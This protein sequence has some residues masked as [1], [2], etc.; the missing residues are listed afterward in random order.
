MTTEEERIKD[1]E[2]Y[3]RHFKV[4][5]LD[6]FFVKAEQSECHSNLRKDDFEIYFRQKCYQ[7][8]LASHINSFKSIIKFLPL[9]SGIEIWK[10][11]KIYLHKTF[12]KFFDDSSKRVKKIYKEEKMKCENSDLKI[13]KDYFKSKY[14]FHYN[15]KDKFAEQI[16]GNENKQRYFQ[17]YNYDIFYPP[18]IITMNTEI[19]INLKDLCEY[20]NINYDVTIDK[21]RAFSYSIDIFFPN[22][23]ASQSSNFT[24]NSYELTLNEMFSSV[25]PVDKTDQDEI[26]LDTKA[27]DVMRNK[28]NPALGFVVNNLEEGGKFFENLKYRKFNSCVYIKPARWIKYLCIH[29]KVDNRSIQ[30]KKTLD[31]LGHVDSLLKFELELIEIVD[32]NTLNRLID[33]Y[34]QTIKS[35]V[36]NTIR[37]VATSKE[38]KLYSGLREMVRNIVNSQ[39]T[40]GSNTNNNQ[41]N[42]NS[43]NNMLNLNPLSPTTIINDEYAE[44]VDGDLLKY[45]LTLRFLKL[46]DYKFYILNLLNYFRYV[47]KKFAID[48]YK[49]EN[50]N[51]KKSEDYLHLTEHLSGTLNTGILFPQN[52]HNSEQDIYETCNQANENLKKLISQLP[53]SEYTK[54]NPVIPSLEHFT[55]C[56][57]EFNEFTRVLL[58]EIDETVEYS[59]KLIRIKDNKGNYIIYEATLSDMKQ[60]EE[61]LSKLGTHFITRR[62]ELVVN[63]DQVPN[64]FV[65]RSQVILDLFTSEYDYLYSKFEYVSEMITIY[66][67]TLDIYTQKSLIQVIT[68]IIGNRPIIDLNYHYFTSSYLMESETLSKKAALVHSLI[69]YQK[70]VEINE[71]KAL[72]DYLEKFYWML[73]EAALDLIKHVRLEKSDIELIKKYIQ[74]KKIEEKIHRETKS[75]NQDTREQ[76]TTNINFNPEKFSDLE[77]LISLFEYFSNSRQYEDNL[78]NIENHNSSEDE[79]NSEKKQ[80]INKNK[81]FNQKNVILD[82][83]PESSRRNSVSYPSETDENQ[84]S[85]PKRTSRDLMGSLSGIHD[86]FNKNGPTNKENDTN[87][88]LQKITILLNFMRKVFTKAMTGSM[89]DFLDNTTEYLLKNENLGALDNIQDILNTTIDRNTYMGRKGYSSVASRSHSI[90]NM[91]IDLMNYKVRSLL[92]IPNPFQ[93]G[94]Y[95]KYIEKNPQVIGS[96]YKDLNFIKF[97]EGYS[98]KFEPESSSNFPHEI[99]FFESLSAL[100]PLIDLIEKTYE[101]LHT[102][103]DSKDMVALNGLNICY[104]DNLM[105]NWQTFKDDISGKR[106]NSDYEG[107]YFLQNSI[108]DEPQGLLYIIKSLTASLSDNI[109]RVPKQI[110]VKLP[111]LIASRIEVGNLKSNFPDSYKDLD[112]KNQN[113]ENMALQDLC[114]ALMKTLFSDLKSDWIKFKEDFS[115]ISLY[116]NLF[117]MYRTKGVIIKLINDSVQLK[118]IYESQKEFILNRHEEVYMFRESLLNPIYKDDFVEYLRFKNNNSSVPKY[119]ISEFDST[120]QNCINF[121]DIIQCQINILDNGLIE[122]KTF[123]QYEYMDY[124]LLNTA[125]Q[126]NANMFFE[127]MKYMQEIDLLENYQ[128]LTF[129][130]ILDP[131]PILSSAESI[132]ISLYECRNKVKNYLS[133][134]SKEF[135]YSILDKKNKNRNNI[136]TRYNTFIDNHIKYSSKPQFIQSILLRQFRMLVVNAYTKDIMLETFLDLIKLQSCKAV[137]N[138]KNLIK[139][140]PKEFL[141]GVFEVNNTTFIE[142]LNK[143]LINSMFIN[144]NFMYYYD[145]TKPWTNFYIPS[146][147]E[148]LRLES[149]T[150]VDVVFHYSQ[151]NPFS[152]CEDVNDPKF[153]SQIKT[154]YFKS[155]NYCTKLENF[156]NKFFEEAHNYQSN[157]LLLLQMTT[158]FINLINLKFLEIGMAQKPSDILDLL[159]CNDWGLDF[160]GDKQKTNFIYSNESDFND[161][162]LPLNI[163]ENIVYNETNYLAL[164]KD[165]DKFKSDLLTVISDLKGYLLIEEPER[166]SRIYMQTYTKCQ[167]IFW[168]DLLYRIRESCIK[169]ND[170]DSSRFITNIISRFKNFDYF[171]NNQCEFPCHISHRSIEALNKL[172]YNLEKVDVRL[173]FLNHFNITNNTN[174]LHGV[175]F[176]NSDKTKDIYINNSSKSVFHSRS[177]SLNENSMINET[178]NHKDY[179]P[180]I[181][182]SA[183]NEYSNGSSNSYLINIPE[184]IN[185]NYNIKNNLSSPFSLYN[186]IKYDFMLI[187]EGKI[188]EMRNLSFKI[189]NNTEKYMIYL[190]QSRHNVDLINLYSKKIEFLQIFQ[191]LSEFKY[192]FMILVENNLNFIPSYKS[193]YEKLD[194]LVWKHYRHLINE[195]FEDLDA[196]SKLP[197]LPSS[198]RNSYLQKNTLKGN[199]S[200]RVNEETQESNHTPKRYEKS[201]SLIFMKL[202]Q[203]EEDQEIYNQLFDK[204]NQNQNKLENTQLIET[205]FKQ[206][207]KIFYVY[208]TE[209]NVHYLKKGIESF[210]KENKAMLEL[211]VQARNDLD[212]N[213]FK[214]KFSSNLIKELD[215]T[216]IININKKFSFFESFINTIQ[217]VSEEVETHGQSHAVLISKTE[218]ENAVKTLIKDFI[219]Y[220]TNLNKSLHYANSSEK[221]GFYFTIKKL[222]IFSSILKG[223]L[224]DYDDN[225]D[226]ISNAK[227]ALSGNKLV[228]EMDNLYRQLKVLKDNIKVMEQYIKVYFDEKFQAMISSHFMEV[229]QIGAKF[230]DF[231][232]EVVSSTVQQITEEYNLCLEELKKKLSALTTQVNLIKEIQKPQENIANINLPSGGRGHSSI[233]I[234]NNHEFNNILDDEEREFYDHFYREMVIE[235]NFNKEVNKERKKVDSLND[236]ISRLHAFYRMKLNLQKNNYEKELHELKQNLSSNKDLWDKLGIAERNEKILKEELSKTQK[237]LASS[238][239]FTKK[240]QA[241]IRKLHDKNVNLEKQL[242]SISAQNIL[243]NASKSDYKAMELYNETKQTYVYNMKNNVN[244]LA[245]IEKVKN[246]Y[247]GDPDIKIVLE[248]LE[249][250]HT[251]YSQEVENKRSYINTLNSIKKDIQKMK[252]TENKKFEELNLVIENL[253]KENKRYKYELEKMRNNLIY[254][255]SNPL[256]NQNNNESMNTRNTGSNSI[257]TSPKITSRTL[258]NFDKYKEQ[259]IDSGSQKI[260]SVGK[261]IIFGNGPGNPSKGNNK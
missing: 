128:V 11:S 25:L 55:E 109:S 63:T 189:S 108:L 65:D 47:Q 61:D 59:D 67:N 46:R 219:I 153:F 166:N 133:R 90:S 185:F 70:K 98:H 43:G 216:H 94:S 220:D 71:N 104:I 254:N 60:L 174:P 191:K 123:A 179:N 169:S 105:E 252:D 134:V 44:K 8:K 57:K 132:N 140:I 163:V 168:L 4:K 181:F 243:N 131:G 83:L 37:I 10:N 117:E 261:S 177:Q 236:D 176:L 206:T 82:S 76:L 31:N 68:D 147:L 211:F 152:F 113:L 247:K 7:E 157:A 173:N 58:D 12:K 120:M 197:V 56:K 239:E 79:N 119:I 237:S 24:Y 186:S 122:L 114:G 242:S 183:D 135:F 190:E 3:L 6:A 251:K 62:E 45:Y 87:K 214:N 50:K 116:C 20:F 259:T 258:I 96:L 170:L 52:A 222:E 233:F 17:T 204:K 223:K 80:T 145:R 210:R 95:L 30:M 93:E 244:L 28:Y 112:E 36:R 21:G 235:Q 121:K 142:S 107:I 162:K 193:S 2:Y 22:Y 230:K 51:W 156:R 18:L 124:L 64:P 199:Q 72:H 200:N 212:I 188:G 195:N 160:W 226:K 149:Q 192:K 136:L 91:S 89:D 15:L 146:D 33:D 16:M 102:Q 225:I 155:P 13:F 49:I 255:T 249:L 75:S 53:L 81:N 180:N 165:F 125:V 141:S 144:K 34:T 172:N 209:L 118:S 77:N 215:E 229:G 256:P 38:E 205:F 74:E 245:S 92:N 232:Q 23:F 228:Y 187:S 253:I 48:L 126:Q 203:N 227:L 9:K 19:R 78:I 238:E 138:L 207:D 97:E 40:E 158:F 167:I 54:T 5:K 1:F 27:T 184:F 148:I 178:K 257:N 240:L 41:S 221:F 201:S 175:N 26:L 164:R 85:S 246:N 231:K 42:M 106:I 182:R 202:M 139:M 103:F 154:D 137:K 69:D 198:K 88:N 86:K 100:I 213:K 218:L 241:Q 110:L 39:N 84:G 171:R 101:D 150:D 250:L 115:E 14:K 32:M 29:P 194:N 260:R 73:G 129:N 143:N 224:N 234:S 161:K 99:E 151:Y 217:N 130:S 35:R 248:N 196:F 111:Y 66:E 127:P 208:S 159:T